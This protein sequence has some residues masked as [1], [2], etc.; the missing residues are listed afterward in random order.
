MRLSRTF[1]A[2]A[3][4]ASLTALL[5]V[6]L[7]APSAAHA[8]ASTVKSVVVS[9]VPA[10]INATDTP[11]QIGF[12]VSF[13]GPQAT[14]TN[15]YQVANGGT[16]T[17]L[18]VN[19][20]ASVRYLPEVIPAQGSITPGTPLSYRLNLPPN[21]ATGLYQLVI[22]ITQ[23]S[24]DGSKV[25]YVTAYSAEVDFQVRATSAYALNHSYLTFSGKLSK[26]SAWRFNYDG[27]YYHEDSILQ[28]YYKPKGA[29]SYTKLFGKTIDAYGDASFTTT[30]GRI[31]KAGT[32][33]YTVAATRY[34]D[35]IRGTFSIK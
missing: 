2:T 12:T 18:E 13:Q 22:P 20:P 32:G 27:Q 28:V 15:V 19:A 7:Q 3:T 10:V 8:E 9:G 34:A 1:T 24:W 23:A 29:T 21:T 14:D 5:A 11:T 4:L 35:E 30:K 25:N 6:A 17:P 33:Y 16:I 31:L 26:T